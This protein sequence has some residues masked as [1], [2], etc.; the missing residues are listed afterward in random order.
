MKL[1]YADERSASIG[2]SSRLRDQAEQRNLQHARRVEPTTLLYVLD[3]SR[4]QPQRVTSVARG[5]AALLPPLAHELG[6]AG[7]RGLLQGACLQ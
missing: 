6:K 4:G 1:I 7:W 5:H 3:G 2:V